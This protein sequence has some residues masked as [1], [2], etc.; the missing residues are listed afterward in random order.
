MHTQPW[1]HFEGAVAD[2]PREDSPSP[3]QL[4][5]KRVQ[6]HNLASQLDDTVISSETISTRTSDGQLQHRHPASV[7][8]QLTCIILRGSL[9][10]LLST[11]T[12]SGWPLPTPPLP[13]LRASP[14]LPEGRARVA[15]RPAAP[16]ALCMGPGLLQ[17][18]WCVTCLHGATQLAETGCA[19]LSGARGSPEAGLCPV[20]VATLQVPIPKLD[21]AAGSGP[22]LG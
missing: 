20:P 4:S 3:R 6:W 13:S 10:F 9:T 16:T 22:G 21:A 17:G 11:D 19:A 12:S 8:C 14:I 18:V 15:S 2:E 1:L 5:L 7:I